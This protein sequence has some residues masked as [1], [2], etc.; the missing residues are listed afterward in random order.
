MIGLRQKC[1]G[2]EISEFRIDIVVILFI[3]IIIIFLT[4]KT[5][6]MLKSMRCILSS[7]PQP[8]YHY[9]HILLI[10]IT[11]I[12]IIIVTLMMMLKSMRYGSVQCFGNKVS[13]GRDVHCL[14]SSMLPFILSYDHRHHH[15][16]HRH[17]H[18]HHHHHPHI[19]VMLDYSRQPSCPQN[20]RLTEANIYNQKIY[21]TNMVHVN[22]RK[23]RLLFLSYCVVL[24]C[25][26]F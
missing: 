18:H 25:S 4:D 22:V 2:F 9:H 11:I 12:I 26:T 20:G 21:V 1:I 6:M 16:H 17:H 14:F 23:T 8:L 7:S 24:E 13:N 5:M 15:H 10:I 19:Y 3:F